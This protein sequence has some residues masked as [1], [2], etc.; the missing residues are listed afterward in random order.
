MEIKNG[1]IFTFIFFQNFKFLATSFL[2]SPYKKN[3][4]CYFPLP[5][6]HKSCNMCYVPLPFSHKCCL[7]LMSINIQNAFT[8]KLSEIPLWIFYIV[9][10]KLEI[11]FWKKNFSKKKWSSWKFLL[12][13]FSKINKAGFYLKSCS[14]FICII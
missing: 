3:T 8:T 7:P 4:M 2:L 13:K 1:I 5:F 14:C 12:L 9:Y 10:L 6:S 11:F